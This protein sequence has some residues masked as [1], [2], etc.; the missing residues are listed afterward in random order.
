ML[1][2][3]CSDSITHLETTQ[4]A[5]LK[6][7]NPILGD[8][9]LKDVEIRYRATAYCGTCTEPQIQVIRCLKIILVCFDCENFCLFVEFI[10]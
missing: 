5:R 2:Y 3:C 4:D 1:L 10:L 6:A 9:V 8:H 7:F